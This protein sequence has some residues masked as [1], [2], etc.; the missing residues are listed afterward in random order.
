MLS[1]ALLV[2]CGCDVDDTADRAVRQ[3]CDGVIAD[4]PGYLDGAPW[5][6]PRSWRGER[7]ALVA[8]FKAWVKP[9]PPGISIELKRGIMYALALQ[10]ESILVAPPVGGLEKYLGALL[11]DEKKC[12]LGAGGGNTT[13]KGAPRRF[14]YLMPRVARLVRDDRAALLRLVAEGASAA[15]DATQAEND[16][17]VA[18]ETRRSAKKPRLKKMLADLSSTVAHL[19][20]RAR[21][22]DQVAEAGRAARR[23][24][25]RERHGGSRA[26]QREGGAARG[27]FG[28][29]GGGERARGR[30]RDGRGRRARARC[31]DLARGLRAG[32]VAHSTTEVAARREERVGPPSVEAEGQRDL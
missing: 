23:R 1:L 7:R 17:A 8:Q 22:R 14:T 3:W 27:L 16:D 24:H 6:S 10:F 9:P 15:M 13:K 29:R 30:R 18:G 11:A 31:G 32:R 28:K 20:A 25:E 26:P 5:T 19:D 21:N 4:S 2:V 12:L